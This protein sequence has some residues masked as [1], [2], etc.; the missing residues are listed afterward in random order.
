MKEFLRKHKNFY[1]YT[2]A[3]VT[4]VVILLTLTGIF[5]TPFKPTDMDVSLKYAPP[6][7]SHL[8][9][10]D[11]YG[12]DIL[13]RI[14]S[15]MRSTLFI[16]VMTV[17]IGAFFG[18]LLGS[19]T[20]YFGGRIDDIFMRVNDVLF[21]FP[22]ILLSLVIVSVLGSSTIN[23]T[24]ALGISFIPSF[25]RIVRSEYKR[26]LTLDYVA[27]ARLMGAGHF[28]IIF[29]HILPNVIPMIIS[30]VMV[31]FNNAILAEAGLSFLGIGVQPPF[32][33]LG[34][35]LSDSQG[36]LYQAPW[37]AIFVGL[38]IAVMVLGFSLLS[39]GISRENY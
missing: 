6:S 34:R 22:N 37:Y 32:A 21:A 8:M 5:Y 14:M 28:R 20:G 33:S 23:L 25:A 1:F 30:S 18:V 10:C 31:G 16:A 29:V 4:G 2:G 24:I 26:E 39:E 27:S 3:V 11:S 19:V 13:S 12:R 15:G 9:G 7:L 17:F 35:M 36:A 38:T